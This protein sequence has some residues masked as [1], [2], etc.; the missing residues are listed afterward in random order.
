MS[1]KPVPMFKNDG[2]NILIHGKQSSIFDFLEPLAEVPKPANRTIIK[3][4]M[5]QKEQYSSFEKRK[6]H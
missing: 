4:E 5:P 3:K 2:L 6:N 1:S